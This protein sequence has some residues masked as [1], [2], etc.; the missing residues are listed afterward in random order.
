[1][2]K[3]ITTVLL[4]IFWA[5]G[6]YAQSV[7]TAWVQ[8][9]Q[10]PG[11][12]KDYAAAIALDSLSNIYVTGYTAYSQTY[13]DYLTIK[14]DPAGNEL[15]TRRYNGP[16]DSSDCASD[17][18]VD[19]WG[20]VY[21]TGYS[22]G[23]SVTVDDYATIRY[24]S[25]GNEI[26][27]RRY[28]GSAN[29]SDGAYATAVDGA[30]NVYVTGFCTDS[31]SYTDYV[32]I[33]YDSSGNEIWVRSYDGPG[34]SDDCAYDMAVDGPGNIYL[35][36]KST[37][38]GTNFDYAT[39]KYDSS[40]TELWVRRYNGSAN[41]ADE[42]AAIAVDDLGNV[43]VTGHSIG[44]G[45][46]YATIKYDSSGNELWVSRYDGPAS[47]RDGACDIA[48]DGLG[49]VYV[50]GNSTGSTTASDFATV[51]YDSS[52]NQLWVRRYSGPGSYNDLAAGISLDSSGNVYI[53]GYNVTINTACNYVTIK[54][55]TS[56]NELWMQTY[57]G[58]GNWGDHARAIA[59]D[60]S[61][62]VYVTGESWG[63]SSNYDYA[64]IKYVQFIRGDVNNDHD[65]TISDVVYLINYLFKSGAAPIPIEQVGDV[66]CDGIDDIIDAVYL[67]NY[68]FKNG[69]PPCH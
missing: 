54:Y 9:Y 66:N 39:I 40:G 5:V 37:G 43:Y 29:M 57:N 49:N 20:N 13:L 34:N 15:W 16:G 61:G 1:M 50:I 24:D 33:K 35:T 14:Y 4:I 65:V 42:A 38:N 69:P 55:D 11:N 30:G 46:D 32:T 53:T 3:K 48:V 19:N 41:R 18:A 8:R 2:L 56:G 36:G 23:D 25:S 68:L 58:P 62:N 6:A 64:T 45:Y 12:S 21:V 51:K 67:V 60:D 31:Q 47:G 59:L 63:I 17:I 10:G 26:W 7:D 52:G 27:T 44:T 22:Y 28:D